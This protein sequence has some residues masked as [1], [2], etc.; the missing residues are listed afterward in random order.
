MWIC[1]QAFHVAKKGN[2]ESEYEDAYFPADGFHRDRHM[3]RC[4]V[5]DGATE[6]AFS[7]P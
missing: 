6:S 3:Y 5:A 1:T 4:A 7:G 2:A